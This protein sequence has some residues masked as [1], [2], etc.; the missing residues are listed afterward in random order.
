MSKLGIIAGGGIMPA[1]LVAACR[2]QGREVFVLALKGHADES[3]L[4]ADVPREWITLG[5]GGRGF[6]ILKGQGV[7][8]IVMVGPV[9]RPSLKELTPDWRTVRFFAK[10]GLRA[11]GDDGLLKALVAELEREGFTVIGVDSILKD[12]VAPAGLWG[13]HKPDAQ[14]EADIEI[15]I[16]AARDLGAR[17]I[18]QAAVAQ[19]GQV[20]AVEDIEGTTAL[21]R[22]AGAA[23]KPGAKPVLAKTAKPNQEMR[24]DMPT[25]GAETV[26]AAAAAGFAGI[27]VQAGATLVVDRERCIAAADAAGLFMIGV[28]IP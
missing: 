18:G 8:E 15:G 6:T 4:P 13:R 24:V 28:R 25:I 17:D 1:R 9:R 19:Q 12:L 20:L 26:A 14:G 11:L 22:R 3:A 7:R 16:K 10:A 23:K 2:A 27:A 5:E 21:I